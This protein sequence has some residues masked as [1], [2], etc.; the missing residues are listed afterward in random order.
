MKCKHMTNSLSLALLECETCKGGE[1]KKLPKHGR[2]SS[3]FVSE[4]AS[5]TQAFQL[6]LQTSQG[7]LA[8][9]VTLAKL[10][11]L[12]DSLTNN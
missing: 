6:N 10:F 2:D 5:F 1:V 4:G 12:F 9:M 7:F 11:R 8:L 3:N